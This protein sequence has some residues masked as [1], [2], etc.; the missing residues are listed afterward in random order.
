MKERTF[1]KGILSFGSSILLFV[2]R[3]NQMPSDKYGGRGRSAIVN[4]RVKAGN[5]EVFSA[6]KKNTCAK[7]IRDNGGKMDGKKLRLIPPNS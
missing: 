3:I 4:W 2:C 6:E 1:D 5:R 7:F